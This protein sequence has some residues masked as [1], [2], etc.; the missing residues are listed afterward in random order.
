MEALAVALEPHKDTVGMTA[1]VITVMQFF[2]GIFVVNDIRK[3]GNTDGFACG[4]FLGGTVFCLLNIQFGQMLRDDAMIKVNFIG[5]ALH[6]LYVCAFYL[7]TAGPGK[8]KVW[9]QIGAAGAIAVGI[10]SYVQYE[11][12]KLVEFRFGIILTVVLLLLVGMPLL[13][14]GDILRKKS[15]EG[16]PFPIIF[17]GSLVSLSW[18]LYGITLRNNFIV[19][20]N[21]MALAICLV[22][23]SLFAIFPSKP[24]TKK[25]KKTN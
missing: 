22:Q 15:T 8:T 14:L 2:S 12:P 3:K 11:D 6:V 25:A 20:Q 19:V 13:G 7:Y 5:L 16:L 4:P 21:L 10:L 1:A 17:S 23:L 24:T 18:L 9:G